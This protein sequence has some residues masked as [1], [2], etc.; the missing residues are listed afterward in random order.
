MRHW[1][2]TRTLVVAFV[3][4][5]ALPAAILG[6]RLIA[7]TNAMSG[8]L[9]D[10]Q[11]RELGRSLHTA[12]LSLSSHIDRT[13]VERY[14]DAQACGVNTAL[15]YRRAWYRVGSPRNR[16]VRAANRYVKLYGVYTL[17]MM[18]DLSG[19]VVAVNDRDANG[20][21]LD[22]TW[23]YDKQFAGASWFEDAKAGRFL[24]GTGADTGNT[25]TTGSGPNSSPIS[26]TVVQDVYVD[27]DVKKICGGDGLTLGFSAPVFDGKGR[28]IG[29]WNN[30]AS[31]ALVDAIVA[32]AARDL[33]AQGLDAVNLTLVD[34]TG[35]IH[36]DYDS[37]RTS[38]DALSH[39][40]QV[41]LTTNLAERGLQAAQRVRAG[42]SGEARERDPR[43]GVWQTTGYAASHG[44]GGFPGLGWGVLAR[45]DDKESTDANAKSAHTEVFGVLATSVLLLGLAAWGLGRSI[46]R[47]VIGG[48]ARLKQNAS[49]VSAVSMELADASQSLSIGAGDQAAAIEASSASMEEMSS[50]TRQNATHAE[51]AAS[52]M[53]NA[54]DLVDGANV[55]LGGM[56]DSMTA[57]QHATTGI[58]KIIK[59]IDE[60]AFQSNLLALNAAIEA[61][62]AGA[63]GA[64]FGVVADEVRSLAQRSAQAAK[65]TSDLIE[66]SIARAGEGSRRV[67]EVVHAMAAITERLERLNGLVQQVKTASG[68]QTEGIDQVTHALAQMGQATQANA[69]VA[70]QSA[71]TSQE[72][73]AVANAALAVI[74]SL[75]RIINGV[76]PPPPSSPSPKAK[77]ATPGRSTRPAASSPKPTQPRDRARTSRAA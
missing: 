21:T 52:L 71:A 56:V 64:G 14:D 28:V 62:R 69:A 20:K 37:A 16:I 61:A 12:A 26:G 5:G 74:A 49:Q 54:R 15:L 47:P 23:L 3:C 55:A 73:T 63:A 9:T 48:I 25:S 32:S 44:A 77:P 4:L 59:T 72:L 7:T 17:A 2:L 34:R 24:N 58:S 38:G 39:D 33:K 50:M 65:D 53:T 51:D 42:N 27:E 43:R 30:R 1:S 57:I 13:L 36:A 6:W 19:R 75:E 70:E 29:V 10:A 46:T 45:I 11:S 68:Q 66:A 60:L 40:M 18:V 67:D 8:A 35:R 31:F 22:T 76:T 41:L